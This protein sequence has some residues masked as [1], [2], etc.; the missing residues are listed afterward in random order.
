MTVQTLFTDRRGGF[1]A[2]PY[3]TFNLA[4][5]VGDDPDAVGR[6]RAL[7]ERRIGAEK[8]VWME[9]I[10]GDSVRRVATPTPDTVSACDALVTDRPGIALAV[11][12][13]DCIPLLLFD[14]SRGVV[15]A[16]HAGRNGTFLRIAQKS[17][18]AMKRLFGCSPADIAA[19]MGPSI[20]PCC[21]EIGEDLAALVKKSFGREFMKGRYLDL[22]A[23]N[24]AQLEEAGLERSKIAMPPLCTR[25]SPD[26]FSYRREGETGRFAGVVWLEP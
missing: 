17:V 20:G 26:H 1:S 7:L 13:A 23:L 16:V 24:A 2:P 14:R 5:H 22:A 3:D 9:Q 6:N 15:A 19:C 11:M 21:Y 4:L 10:H 8:I 18:E 25:C 12:V